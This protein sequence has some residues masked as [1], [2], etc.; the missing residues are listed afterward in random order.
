MV[1]AVIS[2][3]LF[4]TGT[5]P[6]RGKEKE[7]DKGAKRTEAPA[8]SRAGKVCV[9]LSLSVRACARARGT[10]EVRQRADLKLNDDSNE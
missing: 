8:S 3:V 2:W 6:E 7:Q 10:A 9:C 5:P 1:G 4:K